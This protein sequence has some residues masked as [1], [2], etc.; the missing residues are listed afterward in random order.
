[1]R[2]DIHRHA[3]DLILRSAV[4]PLA[5]AESSWLQQH[6]A[7][8]PSCA[9][10]AGELESIVDFVRSVSVAI[11]PLLVE[12]TRLRVR[13]RA[14]TLAQRKPS[15][16]L[17]WAS[18]AATWAWM[19]LSAPHIWRGFA[20]VGGR[21]GVPNWAWEMGFGLWWL[22]PALAVGAALILYRSAGTAAGNGT[23]EI[24]NG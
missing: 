1:M 19:A 16:G 17:L 6:L 15:P 23:V 11:N 7:E 21:L 10:E 22:L 2:E 9:R 5:P 18:C 8:C 4:E 14:R 13:L 24:W 20:W 12:R 3:E